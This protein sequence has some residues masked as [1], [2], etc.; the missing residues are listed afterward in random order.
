MEQLKKWTEQFM[1][2]QNCY[3]G[4]RE[5][6]WTTAGNE[7][8]RLSMQIDIGRQG[9]RIRWKR[10]LAWILFQSVIEESKRVWELARKNEEYKY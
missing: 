10:E 7:L 6:R 4:G 3:D 2:I 1:H 8:D 5:Y 9:M